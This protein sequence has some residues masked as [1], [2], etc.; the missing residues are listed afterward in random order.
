[1]VKLF[2]LFTWSTFYL[3]FVILLNEIKK[4]DTNLPTTFLI[5]LYYQAK[6]AFSYHNLLIIQQ[7]FWIFFLCYQNFIITIYYWFFQTNKQNWLLAC[8]LP[9]PSCIFI[10]YEV[11]TVKTN[12][13]CNAQFFCCCCCCCCCCCWKK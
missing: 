2:S 11:L 6:F 3:L 4:P 12:K 9:V 10:I 8:L 7:K 1:M 13:K 5:L